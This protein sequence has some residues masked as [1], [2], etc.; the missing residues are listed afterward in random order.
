[1]E[2]AMTRGFSSLALGALLTLSMGQ[3]IFAGPCDIYQSGGTPCVA[4]HSTTRALYSSYSGNLYQVRRASDNKVQD[5]GVLTAGGVANSAIQDQFCANTSCTI[6]KIYDQSPKGN[7]LVVTPPGG[8]G[9]PMGARRRLPLME[10][11]CWMVIP[12]TEFTSLEMAL[13]PIPERAIGITAP[14]VFPRETSRRASTRW[15][16]ENTSTLGVAS[17]TETRR[18]TTRTM[19]PVQWRLFI[20]EAAPNGAGGAAMVLG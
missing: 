9:C 2:S 20:S 7:H 19:D 8:C 10:R 14:R 13:P 16:V 1:M 18:R 15:L 4:A 5:I 6:S 11:S 12:F 17:T 3:P